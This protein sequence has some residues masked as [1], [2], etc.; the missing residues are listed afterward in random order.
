MRQIKCSLREKIGV[1][2]AQA[3]SGVGVGVH[4]WAE[5]ETDRKSK[6]GREIPFKSLV[7]G[8]GPFRASSG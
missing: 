1:E 8:G 7:W 6:R 3:G 4:E 5:R 2:K